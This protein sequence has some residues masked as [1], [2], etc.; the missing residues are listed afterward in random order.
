MKKTIKDFIMGLKLKYYEF[1]WTTLVYAVDHDWTSIENQKIWH[2]ITYSS[3]EWFRCLDYFEP[4][5]TKKFLHDHYGY[6]FDE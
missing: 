5:T 4:G 1:I 2:A 3:C 6:N